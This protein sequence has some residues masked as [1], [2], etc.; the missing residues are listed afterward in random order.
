M[1]SSFVLVPVLAAASFVASCDDSESLP[2]TCAGHE[3]LCDRRFDQVAFAATHNSMADSDHEIFAF[4]Q[5]HDV[6]QQLEDGIRGF[7]IDLYDRSVDPGVAYTCHGACFDNNYPFVDVLSVMVDHLRSNRDSILTIVLENN[8]AAA[9]IDV[10]MRESGASRYAY[11]H[12]KGT[13]WPT[14]REMIAA[15]HRLVILTD[16]EGGDETS[17]FPWLMDQWQ[18]AFQNNYAAEEEADFVCDVHRGTD[19]PN[20]LFVMNHFLTAPIADI[21]FATMVNPYASLH[22][23]VARCQTELGRIPNLVTVDFYEVG[24]VVWVVDELNGFVSGPPPAP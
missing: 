11:G 5:T 2:S 23:H 21:D 10:A 3:E 6:A 12:V 24:D 4:C 17:E 9:E 20:S 15:N 16:S 7:M 19:A 13:P 8:V 14:L 18:Y 22:A 1:R